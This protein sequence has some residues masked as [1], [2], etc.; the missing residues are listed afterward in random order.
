MART[1]RRERVARIKGG[2]LIELEVVDQYGFPSTRYAEIEEIRHA[3]RDH[4]LD[5]GEAR[6]QIEAAQTLIDKRSGDVKDPDLVQDLFN[7]TRAAWYALTLP[8]D[9]TPAP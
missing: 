7:I 3:L 2:E 1:D 4:G 6:R 8:S 5:M 9:T